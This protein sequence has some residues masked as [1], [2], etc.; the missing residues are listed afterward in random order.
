MPL[1][2]HALGED[3]GKV[4]KKEISFRGRENDF[5]PRLRNYPETWSRGEVTRILC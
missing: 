3:G 2:R 1:Y 5:K 4:S